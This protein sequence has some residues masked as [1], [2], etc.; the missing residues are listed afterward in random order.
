M[1]DY[2]EFHEALKLFVQEVCAAISQIEIP[3]RPWTRIVRDEQAV[4]YPKEERSD[5]TWLL[6]RLRIGLHENPTEALQRVIHEARDDQKLR[7]LLLRDAGGKPITDEKAQYWITEQICGAFL[8]AYFDRTEN[9]AFDETTFEDTFH[10]LITELKSPLVTVTEVSPLINCR[11]DSSQVEI[12]PWLA[13][14]KLTTDELEK[15]LN[16]YTEMPFMAFHMP[17]LDPIGSDCAIEVTYERG[18]HEGWGSSR[19]VADSVADLLTTLRLLTDRSIH[20]AF[21]RRKSDSMLQPGGGTSSNIRPRL[22]ATAAH[23]DSSMQK[24]IIDAWS[25]IRA[26]A[27]NPPVKLAL[28]RWDIVS[29]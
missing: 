15:E 21:T 1:A 9:Q 5:L 29:E 7:N 22:L 14:R 16:K 26:L 8:G 25:R 27:T 12:A 4:S 3:K 10:Q 2:T 28:R 17:P 6:V 13:I 20:I 24:Q 19:E 23:V 18:R 11:L